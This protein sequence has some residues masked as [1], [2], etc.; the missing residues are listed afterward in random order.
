MGMGCVVGRRCVCPIA[1]GAGS[2][3]GSASHRD[4]V[5]G[6]GLPQ[7]VIVG[8]ACGIGLAHLRQWLQLGPMRP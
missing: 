8:I 3:M 1:G 7:E 5:M 4:A 2:G 6:H